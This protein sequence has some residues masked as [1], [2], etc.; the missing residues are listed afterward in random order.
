MM[1]TEQHIAEQSHQLLEQL[2]DE[3]IG[4]LA[5]VEK[6]LAIVGAPDISWEQRSVDTGLLRALSGRRRDFLVVEHSKL[7][8]YQ[9]LISARAYGTALMVTWMLTATPRLTNEIVRAMRLTS[10]AKGRHDIGAEL[11]MFALIDL[12]AFIAITRLVLK[13]AVAD[14]TDDEET[15][16][17]DSSSETEWSPSA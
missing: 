10:D 1:L 9:V 16:Q 17:S 11:D 14:L 6:H 7:R 8:E 5:T 13:K 3:S 15:D 2:G 12:N 4:L